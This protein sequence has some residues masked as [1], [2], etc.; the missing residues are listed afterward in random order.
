[1]RLKPL[2][3]NTGSTQATLLYHEMNYKTSSHTRGEN[4]F[5]PGHESIRY[6]SLGCATVLSRASYRISDNAVGTCNA[7]RTGSRP[8]CAG[9]M[10]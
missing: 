8:R 7:A 1:M 6:V 2:R 3:L 5:P 10:T 9:T 4:D